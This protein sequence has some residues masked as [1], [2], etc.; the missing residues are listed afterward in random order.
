MSNITQTDKAYIDIM[1]LAQEYHSAQDISYDDYGNMKLKEAGKFA[2]TNGVSP[3]SYDL[4]ELALQSEIND[5]WL[6]ELMRRNGR[7]TKL[8]TGL[9]ELVPVENL[10][11]LSQMVWRNTYIQVASHEHSKYSKFFNA[12]VRVM[13]DVWRDTPLLVSRGTL[14]KNGHIWSVLTEMMFT[15][16]GL[17]KL[18]MAVI[19]RIAVLQGH[20]AVTL[21]ASVEGRRVYEHIGYK[22]RLSL[23]SENGMYKILTRGDYEGKITTT[24]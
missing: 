10:D 7:P 17:A 9:Q 8:Q 2:K 21:D 13:I 22:N 14:R 20:E 23:N 18:I 12:Y 15:G 5:E 6:E 1:V 3:L 24:D 19:E 16:L 4:A 11:S